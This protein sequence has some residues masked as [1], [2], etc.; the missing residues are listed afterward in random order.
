MARRTAPS[1]AVAA[2]LL[3]LSACASGPAIAAV[4]TDRGATASAELGV[5]QACQ[6]VSELLSTH[7]T[8]TGLTSRGQATDEQL[9]QAEEALVDA[10]RKA[11]AEGS[12]E[13]APYFEK[14]VEAAGDDR[15]DLKTDPKMNAALGSMTALCEDAGSPIVIRVEVGG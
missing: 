14:L 13:V 11:A 12:P 8:M 2:L 7:S 4:S 10:W 6:L 1:L 5:A 15:P 3:G 9:S